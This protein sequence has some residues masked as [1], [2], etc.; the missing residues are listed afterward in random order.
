MIDLIA[1]LNLALIYYAARSS[2]SILAIN[3]PLPLAP[4]SF[5]P[6]IHILDNS[7]KDLTLAKFVNKRQRAPNALYIYF[8]LTHHGLVFKTVF[9]E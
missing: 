1:A 8:T 2:Q 3:D 4:N 5:Y 9:S 6:F 7:T